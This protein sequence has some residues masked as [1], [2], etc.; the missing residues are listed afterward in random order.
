MLMSAL[1]GAIA[2]AAAV[3]MMDL[4]T[5][6]MFERQGSKVT[7][8]EEAARPNDQPALVNL[9]D[10]LEDQSKVDL[11]A[12]QRESLLPLLHYALGVVPGA[13]YGVLHR[14]PL[15]RSA[16]GAIYGVLLWALNDE[17]LNTK[18]GL[19]GPYDAYPVETHLRGL[20]GHIVLGITTD[21]GI[22]ILGG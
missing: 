10:R 8:R 7:K 13:V 15:V 2:G 4:V 1:R 5:T 17:Y 3:W 9:I 21:T 12:E 20:F 22:S 16:N 11:S 14:A 19:A 18:L 6:A